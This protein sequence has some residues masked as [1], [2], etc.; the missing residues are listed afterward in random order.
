MF[1]FRFGEINSAQKVHCGTSGSYV[2]W[3]IVGM[4]RTHVDSRDYSSPIRT[5]DYEEADV[6]ILA[7]VVDWRYCKTDRLE[8]DFPVSGTHIGLAFDPAAYSII[9]ARL[10]VVNSERKM[11]K[12]RGKV[13]LPFR[14][15]G[16]ERCG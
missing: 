1:G 15:S 9:A 6:P 11:R 13:T 7:E 5:Q 12:R 3:D 10:A 4:L 16:F 14:Q 8:S 2:Q